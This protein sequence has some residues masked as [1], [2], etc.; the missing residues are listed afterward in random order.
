LR[1]DQVLGGERVQAEPGGELSRLVVGR[2]VEVVPERRT[3][4]VNEEVGV[5]A[6]D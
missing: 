4:L 5:T 6:Q 2:I 3:R 1:R